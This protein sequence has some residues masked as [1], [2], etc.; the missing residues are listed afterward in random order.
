MKILLA[1]HYYSTHGGGIEIVASALADRLSARH[2]IAWA[3]SDCDAFAGSARVRP[4]PMRSVNVVERLTG[5]PFPLWGPVSLVRLWREVRRADVV[6][7]HD[8]AY[9]GN[10]AAFVFAH[11]S[12]RPV[13]V[14]QHVGFIPYKSAVL[15]AM[16]VTLHRTIGRLMLGRAEQVVFISPLVRDY[17]GAIVGYRTPPVL[18][19]NGVDTDTFRAAGPGDRVRARAELGLD[20]DAPVMVFVGRFVEKKGLAL[21]E[22]LARAMPDV[23]WLLAGRGPIDPQS[24][25]APNVRVV[26]GRSGTGLVPLYHAAD[27][28]VLPSVGEG[29]PLVVQE[30]MSCGTPAIVGVDTAQAVDAPADLVFASPVESSD[31]AA[32]WDAAIR[33]AVT[34]LRGRPDATAR[35]AAFA[36]ARWSWQAC[37]DGY[38][39][40]LTRLAAG[41]D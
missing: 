33:R 8:F 12:G 24:W 29:L 14:T 3:A 36:R 39:A 10:V 25:H 20:P 22:R 6:H 19:W 21:I 16:L 41:R 2:E 30:A 1:T 32:A 27:L 26:T 23:T 38:D 11:A 35:A 15:R 31:A 5:L 34:D 28:L 13:L 17:F 4:L 40:L 37:A 9:M 7:L 18:V